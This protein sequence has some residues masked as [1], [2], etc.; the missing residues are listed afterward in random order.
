MD[1]MATTEFGI[2]GLALCQRKPRRFALA[3]RPYTM[4]S[5]RPISA[6]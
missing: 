1:A 6:M 3:V 5:I 2:S 4:P